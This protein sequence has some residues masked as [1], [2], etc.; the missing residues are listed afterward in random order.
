MKP[1]GRGDAVLTLAFIPDGSRLIASGRDKTLSTWKT[2]EERPRVERLNP[3]HHEQVNTLTVWPD[4]QRFASGG[5]DAE[6]RIWSLTDGQPLGTLVALPD[7]SDWVAYTPDGQFDSSPGAERRITWLKDREVLPL[8]QFRD[9]LR[10]FRLTDELRQGRRP[11]AVSAFRVATPPPNLAIDRPPS[12]TID[13][14]LTL[15]I[16][17]DAP[18]VAN[19][20]LYQNDLPVQAGQDLHSLDPTHL[21]AKVQLRKG[22]NRFYVMGGRGDATTF[23][24]RSN[25]VVVRFDGEEIPGHLHVL[26]LGVSQYQRNPL[27]YADSD[28]NAI[29]AWLG[30]HGADIQPGQG[31]VAVLTNADVTWPNV[32]R[33]LG[34]LRREVKPEDTVVLFLAGHADILRTSPR[35]TGFCLLLDSFPFPKGA[36]STLGLRGVAPAAVMPMADTK[37]ALPYP[38]IYKYIARLQAQNRLIIIDACRAAAAAN[39]PAVRRIEERFAEKVDDGAQRARTSYLL[40]SRRDELAIEVKDLQHGLLTHVL[41]W[42]LGDPKLKLPSNPEPANAD[43]DQNQVVTTE[44]LR[45]FAD[46]TMPV[47]AARF[48]RQENTLRAGGATPLAPTPG[49][50]LQETGS[51]PFPLARIPR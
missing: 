23:D 11:L 4:G 26:A 50:T 31:S 38:A 15:S 44:E 25:E 39:D 8:D 22:L 33:E 32:E 43:F 36:T 17:L 1:K 48:A 51:R 12:V 20:R 24:G 37:T 49:T 46:E 21:A 35:E 3:P 7:S 16:A 42:G 6:V 18:D 30:E 19:L 47:L 28:A 27:A 29:A 10:V 5:D 2:N 40:A 41:L 14:D 9:R 34:R 13:R 45:R